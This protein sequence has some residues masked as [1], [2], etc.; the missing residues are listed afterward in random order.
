MKTRIAVVAAVVAVILIGLATFVAVRAFKT[1]EA[2]VLL[3][4]HCDS[5]GGLPDPACTPGAIDSR[6]TQD[7]I[8]TTICVTGYTA[9]VRPPAAYTNALKRLQIAQYGYSDKDPSHYEEDH[10]IPLELGGSPG[11][12]KNLWPEPE[13]GEGSADA[14]DRVENLLHAR[15]CAG[16]MTLAAAQVAIATDWRTAA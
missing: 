10:L 3:K 16:R 8:A 15:V 4:R 6:V 14:K 11:D 9:K 13:A 2:Q 1:G 7:N 5:A 12:A